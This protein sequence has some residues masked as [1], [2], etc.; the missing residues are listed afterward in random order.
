MRVRIAAILVPVLLIA[1][2]NNG[3]NSAAP[4]AED[5]E[6]KPLVHDV[7]Y[8]LDHPEERKQVIAE[9]DNN[10]GELASTPNCENAFKADEKA[11][12]SG[13]EKAIKGGQ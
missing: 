1:A 10:P 13:M 9:C 3:G 11:M 6:P 7:Q 2:C 8:Y 12:W 5:E 4:K